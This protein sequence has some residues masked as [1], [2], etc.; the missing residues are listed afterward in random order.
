VS[1][2]IPVGGLAMVTAGMA[3]GASTTSEWEKDELIDDFNQ[4]TRVDEQAR[5]GSAGQIA[6]ARRIAQETL[7]WAKENE[8]EPEWEEFAYA[9]SAMA[10]LVADRI[11]GVP[12]F[13][14]TRYDQAVDR[15]NAALAALPPERHPY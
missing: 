8:A 6:E 10:T 14:E 5:P 3:G 12:S 11:A 13:S 7:A 4:L 9:T 1:L 15:I 2:V